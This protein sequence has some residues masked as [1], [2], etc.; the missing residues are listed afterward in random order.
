MRFDQINRENVKLCHGVEYI[1]I[2]DFFDIETFSTAH[3]NFLLDYFVIED[4]GD[5]C[6]LSGHP[7][8]DLLYKHEQ[9]FLNA[10]NRVWNENCIANKAAA[11]L[12][13]AGKS[14]PIHNDT[15]WETV[16]IRGVLYLNDVCGTTFHSSK[17]GNDPI[18]I[19]GKANQLLLFKVTNNSFHSVGLLEHSPIDRF[20]VTMM[21]D[22]TGRT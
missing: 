8:V 17:T 13:P 12:L 19:G 6:S 5:I 7:L 2:D 11:T 3:T 16:P 9:E 21:I 20:S 10:I 15:H 18:D 4:F 1:L 14:L 22:R